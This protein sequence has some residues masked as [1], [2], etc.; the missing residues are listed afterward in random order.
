M[1]V[2]EDIILWHNNMK[3]H[4]RIIW[5]VCSVLLSC[6]SLEFCLWE[7]SNNCTQPMHDTGEDDFPQLSTSFFSFRPVTTAF[8][9]FEFPLVVKEIIF[10]SLSLPGLLSAV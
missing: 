10:L 8:K 7:F 5:N 3:G 2:L 9:T 1:D 6:P 4:S